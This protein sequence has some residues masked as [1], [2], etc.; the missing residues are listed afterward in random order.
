M[1]VPLSST[2]DSLLFVFENIANQ[3]AAEELFVCTS[4]LVFLSHYS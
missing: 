3:K 1:S 4:A 2:V